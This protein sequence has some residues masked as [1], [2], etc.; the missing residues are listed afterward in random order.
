MTEDDKLTDHQIQAIR[1]SIIQT[2]RSLIGTPYKIGQNQADYDAGVGKWTDFSHPPANL[3]CSGLVAACFR[4]NGLK[5]VDGSQNQFNFTIKTEYP[6]DGD[7]GFFG[8]DR[9]ISQIYH[10][11]ILY[12]DQVVEARAFDENAK[13]DTGRVILRSMDKWTNWRNWAG[14]RSHPRLTQIKAV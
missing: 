11:G 5:M 8:H 7:L 12:A 6:Q 4:K 14:W 9:D 1:A 13:F 10:V 3:D 2:A